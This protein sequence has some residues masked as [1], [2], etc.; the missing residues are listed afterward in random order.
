MAKTLAVM[1]VSRRRNVGEFVK[2]VDNIEGSEVDAIFRGVSRENLRNR[3][4][5]V[6]KK[7]ST[8]GKTSCEEKQNVF[9]ALPKLLLTPNPPPHQEKKFSFGGFLT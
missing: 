2:N 7:P 6:I 5:L 3:K 9:Q 4:V 8:K 1:V